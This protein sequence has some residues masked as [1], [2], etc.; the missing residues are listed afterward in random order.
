MKFLNCKNTF[1]IFVCSCY[2]SWF[3]LIETNCWLLMKNQTIFLYS[4]MYVLPVK[5]KYQPYHFIWTF[6][7]IASAN[8]LFS[9]KNHVKWA[10][11]DNEIIVSRYIGFK[12]FVWIFTVDVSQHSKNGPKNSRDKSNWRSI[13][14]NEK[15][16]AAALDSHITTKHRHAVSDSNYGNCYSKP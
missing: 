7:K 2:I 10:Q 13:P 1:C 6:F 4:L 12:C 9:S 5:N 16:A 15:H 8:N 11:C 14:T 3:I